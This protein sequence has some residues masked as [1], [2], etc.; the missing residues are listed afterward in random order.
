MVG[1]V[2]R[3][4]AIASLAADEPRV[5]ENLTPLQAPLSKHDGDE[6]FAKLLEHNQIRDVRLQ[7]YS[8]AR[9]YRV[10]NSRGSANSGF[11]PG[12]RR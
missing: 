10:T 9:T 6:L 2:T 5:S 3:W 4:P 12:R 1:V 8:V 7:E 11:L